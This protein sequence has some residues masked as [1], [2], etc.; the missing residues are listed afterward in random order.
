MKKI[1]IERSTKLA[2]SKAISQYLEDELDVEIGEFDSEFL[3]D[4]ITEKFASVYYNQGL[5]DAKV[6]IQKK[7][8]DIDDEFYAMEQEVT[9]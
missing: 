8:L 3:V 9:L 7:M 4:F 1:E 5:E 6:I 2:M